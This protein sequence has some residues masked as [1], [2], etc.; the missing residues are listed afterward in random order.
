MGSNTGALKREGDG[1]PSAMPESP[2]AACVLRRL[3]SRV[4][5]DNEWEAAEG[6]GRSRGSSEYEYGLKDIT[7][8]MGDGCSHATEDVVHSYVYVRNRWVCAAGGDGSELRRSATTNPR[9][10]DTHH[11][12]SVETAGREFAENPSDS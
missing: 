8:K 1:K 5:G 3:P 11:K 9:L 10:T 12:S 6:L 2:A 7:D 4:I